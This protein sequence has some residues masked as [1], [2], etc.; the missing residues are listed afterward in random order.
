MQTIQIEVKDN[1][2]QNVMTLLGSL[3]DGM[4]DNIIVK[5]DE[6]KINNE[7]DYFN[8]LS[9]KSLEKEWDNELDAEYDK[10][11]K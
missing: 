10:Y 3:K 11:L 8:K 4:I 7:T 6:L 9:F 2:V 5:N 1:Y